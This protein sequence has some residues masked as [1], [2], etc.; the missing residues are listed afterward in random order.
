M[1][2]SKLKRCSTSSTHMDLGDEYIFSVLTP[3]GFFPLVLQQQLCQW[4]L[5][6]EKNRLC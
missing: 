3:F 4:H 6:M 5:Y 2:E 1:D